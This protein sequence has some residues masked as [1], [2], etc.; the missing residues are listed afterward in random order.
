[1]NR[2][3]IKE[4]AL[5]MLAEICEEDGVKEDPELDLFENELLDSLTVAELLV[6]IEDEFGLVISPTEITREQISTPGRIV[7]LISGRADS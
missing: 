7:S 4:K 5:E 3:E 6:A 1:M 2:E